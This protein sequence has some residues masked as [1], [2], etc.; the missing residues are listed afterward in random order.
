[1]VSAPLRRALTRIPL[2]LCQML[3]AERLRALKC[4]GV[5]KENAEVGYEIWSAR[6]VDQANV[7]A[8]VGHFELFLGIFLGG[9]V[10]GGYDLYLRLRESKRLMTELGRAKDA[11][12]RHEEE[13]VRASRELADARDALAKARAESGAHSVFG[14]TM[15]STIPV[16]AYP[17]EFEAVRSRIG[18]VM[19]QNILLES[20]LKDAVALRARTRELEPLV[21]EAESLRAQVEAESS[22]VTELKTRLG[23]AESAAAHVPRLRQALEAL[24][25]EHRGA[26]LRIAELETQAAVTREAYDHLIS[27]HREALGLLA[28]LRHPPESPD[29]AHSLPTNP[30]ATHRQDL[31]ETRQPLQATPLVAGQATGPSGGDGLPSPTARLVIRHSVEPM[32]RGSGLTGVPDLSAAHAARLSAAGIKT[33]EQLAASSPQALRQIVGDGGADTTGW[34]RAAAR[35]VSDEAP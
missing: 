8:P 11:A 16:Q 2:D 21:A 1:M 9:V 26:A 28:T 15:P 6:L 30:S 35:L 13:A 19:S 25:V 7:E 20:Q 33:P 22:R 10:V 32:A 27:R 29:H 24:M 4:R 17:H 14:H 23:E 34:I 12:R 5:S 18:E 31:A 3:P